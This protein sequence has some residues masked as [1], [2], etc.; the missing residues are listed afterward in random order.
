MGPYSIRCRGAI[1]PRPH[2]APPLTR[3]RPERPARRLAA[4]RKRGDYDSLALKELRHENEDRIHRAHPGRP[5]LDVLSRRRPRRIE[6]G[7][8]GLHGDHRPGEGP[9][10]HPDRTRHQEPRLQHLHHG[11]GRHRPD[12]DDQAAARPAREG[13]QDARRHPLRQQLQV[14]RRARPHP[15]AGRPG[16][17]LRRSDDQAHRDVED[18]RAPA[19]EKPLLHGQARRPHR[20]PAE[21]AAGD[22]P[23]LR[24]AGGRA[25]LFR[26]PGPDGPVQPSRPH[27]RPRGAAHPLRQDRGPGQGK[28]GPQGDAGCPPREVRGAD[29]QARGGLRPAQGDRRGD[30]DAAPGLGRG[31][32]HARHPRRH[33]RHAVEVRLSPRSPP[34]STR[35]RRP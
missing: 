34:T 17:G 10:G 23:G 15:A 32:D 7:G 28:E 25:G 14:S 31:V 9:A 30:A 33:R 6:R 8:Q 2:P 21:E 11:H 22:P 16:Q 4:L 24:G 29:G 20:I 3:G 13:R 18:E 12:D 19:P 5:A 26:H 1:H 27:P 35:S